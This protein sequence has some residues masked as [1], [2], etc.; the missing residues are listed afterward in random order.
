MLNNGSIKEQEA[1]KPEI[2]YGDSMIHNGEKLVHTKDIR[3]GTESAG[4]EVVD[5]N[6]TETPEEKKARIKAEKEAKKL[7]EKEV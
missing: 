7:A 2:Y 4:V 5:E 1:P 6:D 3:E